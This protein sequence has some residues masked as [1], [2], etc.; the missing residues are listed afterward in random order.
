MKFNFSKKN[1]KLNDETILQKPI[2]Y[3]TNADIYKDFL[4]KGLK[5]FES[6]SGTKIE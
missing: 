4:Q 6:L 1:T 3:E 5:R 2:A